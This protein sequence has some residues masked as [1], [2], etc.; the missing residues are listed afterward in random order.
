MSSR[1]GRFSITVLCTFFGIAV[2][3]IGIS[4]LSNSLT[5]QIIG[6]TFLWIGIAGVF[7]GFI[8]MASVGGDRWR[9]PSRS[10]HIRSDREFKAWRQDQRPYESI[11]LG[12]ATGSLLLAIAGYVVLWLAT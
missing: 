5:Y 2:A 8:F 11:V 10:L 12:I 6:N 7:L 1:I 4:V 9:D 3:V